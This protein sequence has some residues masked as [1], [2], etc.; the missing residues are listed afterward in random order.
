MRKS[1]LRRIVGAGI[2]YARCDAKPLQVFDASRVAG[3][4]TVGAE[5]CDAGLLEAVIP[6]GTLRRSYVE[7]HG[8]GGRIDRKIDRR[9]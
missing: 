5:E 4:I 2:R 8:D 1:I 9:A 3:T 7:Y 6:V